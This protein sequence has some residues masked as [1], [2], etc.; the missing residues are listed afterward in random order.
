MSVKGKIARFYNDK[1]RAINS[2]WIMAQ[3]QP[4]YSFDSLGCFIVVCTF[5]IDSPIYLSRW[6]RNGCRYE[7][8]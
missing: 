4:F 6:H 1:P 3:V 8:L 2:L 5:R 7:D